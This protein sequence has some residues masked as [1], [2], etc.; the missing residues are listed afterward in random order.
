MFT[1]EGYMLDFNDILIKPKV[2]TNIISRSD[3]NPYDNN[4]K[5]PLFTAPM[6]TVVNI[7]NA[8][9]FSSCGINV[10]LPRGEETPDKSFYLSYSLTEFKKM[11]LEDDNIKEDVLT[12]GR[13]VLI[14]TANG[15]ISE[16]LDVIKK[17]KSLYGD[18]LILIVGNIANPDTYVN[19]SE[20]GADYVRCGIGNGNG[21]L[22]TQQTGVGFPMASLI[23]Q[24]YIKSLSLDRPAK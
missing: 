2:I 7:D 11:F 20:A 21:C 12:Y 16:M 22:T 19:L 10:C 1:E 18:K 4:F 23:N 8:Y 3:I 9:L 14:D 13:K 15:H 5:L 24:C 6:D 17:A